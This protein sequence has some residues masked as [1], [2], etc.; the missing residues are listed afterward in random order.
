MKKHKLFS[1]KVLTMQ[2]TCGIIFEQMKQNALRSHLA[3]TRAWLI[4]NS[5]LCVLVQECCVVGGVSFARFFVVKNKINGGVSLL[6]QQK[7][8]RSTKTFD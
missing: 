6:A 1:R 8:C 4:F 2:M 3:A 7:T 5:F